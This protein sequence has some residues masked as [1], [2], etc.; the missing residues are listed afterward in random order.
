MVLSGIWW[1]KDPTTINLEKV[2]KIRRTQD[3]KKI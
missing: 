3:E 1:D 2:K